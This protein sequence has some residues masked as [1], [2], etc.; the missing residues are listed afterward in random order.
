MELAHSL[1]I[2]VMMKKIIDTIIEVV[3]EIKKE[4]DVYFTI[5]RFKRYSRASD[6]ARE[7]K[8]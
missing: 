2:L 7:Y 3:E 8:D 5:Q 6:R 4:M 1:L